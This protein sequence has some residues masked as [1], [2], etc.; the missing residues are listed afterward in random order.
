MKKAKSM[1]YSK[2]E[3]KKAFSREA[4]KTAIKMCEK[5]IKNVPLRKQMV[6]FI[7][8]ADGKKIRN[9]SGV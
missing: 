5:M 4:T 8:A 9:T 3:F 1:N 6:A 2:R 7:R